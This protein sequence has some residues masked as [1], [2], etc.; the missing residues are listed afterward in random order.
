[1][2]THCAKIG[3]SP[4]DK[5]PVF[6]IDC[7]TAEQQS[8]EHRLAMSLARKGS[9]SQHW[10]GGVSPINHRVRESVEYKLW[11]E[12][13]FKRDN[14]TCIY[15]KIKGG[16]LNADHIKE[17]AYYPELRFKINNGRTLCVACHLKRHGK[18]N[19]TSEDNKFM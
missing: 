14:W 7:K 6:C 2:C 12:A 9:K 4:T 3:N 16:N 13:V 15:C 19:T 18:T 10:R 17:F 11:R 5:P 8:P 1:M